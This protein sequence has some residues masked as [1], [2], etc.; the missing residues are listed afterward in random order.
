MERWVVIRWDHRLTDPAEVCFEGSK[1]H[2]QQ[3]ASELLKM[4]PIDADCMALS[5]SEWERTRK[6]AP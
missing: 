3:H 1:E 6:L 2:C 4:L 5:E